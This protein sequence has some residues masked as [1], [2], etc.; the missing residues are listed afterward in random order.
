M[1][2][3]IAR[4]GGRGE[5]VQREAVYKYKTAEHASGLP[6][7]ILIESLLLLLSL[8]RLH[9]DGQIDKK[10]RHAVQMGQVIGF[11]HADS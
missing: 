6:C 7:V 9:R 8:S 3:I 4:G 10:L 2:V 1:Q 11:R 5:S